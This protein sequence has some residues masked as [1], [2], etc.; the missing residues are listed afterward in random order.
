MGKCGRTSG[1]KYCVQEVN[2]ASTTL[3]WCLEP[4]LLLCT[5]DWYSL[6]PL[7][8]ENLCIRRL[9]F[10]DQAKA[11]LSTRIK[12]EKGSQLWHKDPTVGFNHTHHL[13]MI[14]CRQ[15]TFAAWQYFHRATHLWNHQ[16]RKQIWGVWKGRVLT[17]TNKR[18]CL[19]LQR[20]CPQQST[21]HERL[22]LSIIQ[23]WNML[24]FLS[25]LIVSEVVSNRKLLPKR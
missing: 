24:A 8:K 7:F 5:T 17:R 13:R 21:Q 10:N 16:A 4:Y 19:D 23:S 22:R 6:E 2:R 11:R 9:Y 25:S 15:Q 20:Y 18:K 1:T 14:R 12:K 3:P